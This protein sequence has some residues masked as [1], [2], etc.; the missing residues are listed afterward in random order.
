MAGLAFVYVATGERYIAEA[1]QSARSCRLQMPACRLLLLTPDAVEPDGFDEVIPFAGGIADPFELKIAG[2]AAVTEERFVF[3][4]TDTYALASIE[5]I[6]DL[7]DRFDLAAAQ[8]PVRLQSYLWPE[9][10]KFLVG[11]P[12]CFPEF[13]TGVIGFKRGPAVTEML[14]RWLDLYREH[15]RQVPPPRTQDQASFREVV[16]MSGLRLATLPPEYNCRFPYP[17]GL[18]GPVKMLHGRADEAELERMGRALNRS[19]DFRVVNRDRFLSH[20]VLIKSR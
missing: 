9:T 10:A 8:A 1:Q 15:A 11:A 6:G 19:R 2:M 12:P 20:S 14:G 5:D 16:Y 7:L 3:L 4:D 18:C 13:N 17:S